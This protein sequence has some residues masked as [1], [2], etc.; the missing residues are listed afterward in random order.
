[1]APAGIGGNN[2]SRA[3]TWPEGFSGPEGFKARRAGSIQTGVSDSEPPEPCSLDPQPQRGDS[4]PPDKTLHVRPVAPP[5]LGVL[6]SIHRGFPTVT[7]AKCFRPVGPE[8][9]KAR[10][11]GP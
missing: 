7:P 2:A 11:T 1:M 5:E 8:Q 3:I 4:E 9:R 10:L 6:L